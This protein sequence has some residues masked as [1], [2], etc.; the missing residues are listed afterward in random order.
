MI[1]ASTCENF[2]NII[3]EGMSF[4]LPILCPNIKPLN[5]IIGKNDFYYDFKKILSL[6]TKMSKFINNTKLREKNGKKN[7]IRAKKFNWSRTSNQTF[8][9][10][11]K[12]L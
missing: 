5:E 8:N 11:E 1:F 6:K 2:P 10:I 9:F 12:F 7:F 4:K 3:L